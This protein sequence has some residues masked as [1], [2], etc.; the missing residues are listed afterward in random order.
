MNVNRKNE[1]KKLVFSALIAA[2]VFVSTAF[3]QIPMG[4]GYVHAGD[5]M[6]LLAAAFLSPWYGFFA[7]ALGSCMADLALGFVAYAPVTFV[8]KGCMVLVFWAITK[9]SENRK[10]PLVRQ[11]VAAVAAE[12]LMVLG[13]FVFEGFLY[14]FVAAAPSILFNAGQ[15]AVGA[16]LGLILVRVLKQA[17]FEE[18]WST[19]QK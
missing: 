14:G 3:I 16:A 6:V 17:R 13:Y 10:R 15:G 19:F 9:S 12:L 11:I 8:V 5:A 2:L 18:F 4:F 1:T 7:A